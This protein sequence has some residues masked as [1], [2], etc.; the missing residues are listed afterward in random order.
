MCVTKYNYAKVK[1]LS[2]IEKIAKLMTIPKTLRSLF[3][4]KNWK[5]NYDYDYDLT[6]KSL[7]YSEVEYDFS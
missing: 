7:N 2:N 6:I 3:K 4:K 5:T 1:C